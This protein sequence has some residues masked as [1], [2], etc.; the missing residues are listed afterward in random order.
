MEDEERIKIWNKSNEGGK[1]V[2]SIES[3]ILENT[4]YSPLN[5]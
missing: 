5:K 1:L 3:K 4:D 2:I